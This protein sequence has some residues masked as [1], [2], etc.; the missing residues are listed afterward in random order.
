MGA[1]RNKAPSTDGFTFKFAQAFWLDLKD[2]VLKM[3]KQFYDMTD[4][5]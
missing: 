5:Y 4:F 1:D 3:F 2:E